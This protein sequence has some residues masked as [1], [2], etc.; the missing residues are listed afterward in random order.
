[1]PLGDRN[2]FLFQQL[3]E[4]VGFPAGV[5]PLGDHH[6]IQHP[7]RQVH[8]RGPPESGIE[9]LLVM[10]ASMR[11]EQPSAAKFHEAVQDIE[12]IRSLFDHS[13]RDAG[14]LGNVERNLSFRIDQAV[15][16]L[17]LL[18]SPALEQQSPE[19]DDFVSVIRVE[20]RRLQIENDRLHL[21]ERSIEHSLLA[22][23]LVHRTHESHLLRI[24]RAE[25][26]GDGRRNAAH[27]VQLPHPVHAF[28]FLHSNL[29]PLLSKPAHRVPVHTPLQ[30]FPELEAAFQ[31]F[32]H[33]FA[34]L[35]GRQLPVRGE[36]SSLELFRRHHAKPH[37][38]AE[39]LHPLPGV[40]GGDDA[41]LLQ[42]PDPS[43]G[44]SLAKIGFNGEHPYGVHHRN[45]SPVLDIQTAR[46]RSVLLLEQ[47][48]E[49]VE[50]H[51]VL[52]RIVQHP[53]HDQR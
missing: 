53:S 31:F 29:P 11:D 49:H 39:R 15:E 6:R 46:I 10:A 8:L 14:Q 40:F 32:S 2:A 13:A 43:E 24:L 4:P 19:A 42:K 18:H 21:L 41:R 48:A 3:V 34:Q 22:Q 45:I 1:M 44:G 47:L 36:L 27:L 5:Q 7:M 37:E 16:E 25:H 38:Q 23:I 30:L 12:E 35:P 50:Q 51:L 26:G 33:F 9:E 20:A 17:I 52:H 28:G